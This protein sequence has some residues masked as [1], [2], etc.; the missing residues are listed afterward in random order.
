MA[1]KEKKETDLDVSAEESTA[2]VTE[3]NKAEGTDAVDTEQ[4][5]DT[6]E[7]E[8]A[9]EAVEE[10][11]SGDPRDKKIADL[12]DRLQRQMAEF[13]NFRRRSDKEKAG[14]YDMGAADVITKVL[15]VVDNFERGLKDFD[16]TDPFADGMNKIYRQLSKV[17]DDLGVKE[18]E[19]EGKEFDPNLHNAVMHEENPEVGESTITAV[20]QKGYTYKESVIRH[21]MVR[22]AN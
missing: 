21:S 18:I 13:E 16:E 7:P 4:D 17:L 3:E 22:V 20:F 6:A 15:D 12:T 10:E 14:M 19:A 11:A 2:E 8:T 5:A 9:E 1:E